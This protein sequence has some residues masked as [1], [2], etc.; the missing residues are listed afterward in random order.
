MI[1]NF[2]HDDLSRLCWLKLMESKTA[3]SC[4]VIGTL[5]YNIIYKNNISTSYEDRYQV[6]T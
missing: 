5:V 4:C 2:T 1:S 6:S 3:M